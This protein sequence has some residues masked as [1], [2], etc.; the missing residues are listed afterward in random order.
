MRPDNYKRQYTNQNYVESGSN[1]DDWGGLWMYHFRRKRCYHQGLG[2]RKKSVS[3]SSEKEMERNTKCPP[4]PIL[5]YLTQQFDEKDQQQR[6]NDGAS[7]DRSGKPAVSTEQSFGAH[8]VA[9]P[10]SNVIG[11]SNSLL[12]L[13]EKATISKDSSAEQAINQIGSTTKEYLETTNPTLNHVSSF[14]FEMDP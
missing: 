11:T 12:K 9:T 14:C 10:E 1:I 13:W 6:A 5:S 7:G 8:N 3:S 2:R 4:G